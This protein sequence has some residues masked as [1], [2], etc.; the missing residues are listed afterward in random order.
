[1]V[2][3]SSPRFMEPRD[4]PASCVVQMH[5]WYAYYAF[6][7]ANIIADILIFTSASCRLL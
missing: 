5:V 7:H 3:S 2:E 4:R 1:M 6:H